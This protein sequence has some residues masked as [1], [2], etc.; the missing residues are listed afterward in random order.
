MISFI[1]H[2]YSFITGDKGQ[3]YGVALRHILT[4]IYYE[5]MLNVYVDQTYQILNPFFV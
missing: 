3:F 2:S 1:V 4:W 5:F